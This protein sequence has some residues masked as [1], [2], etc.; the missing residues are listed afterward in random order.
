MNP[1]V[2]HTPIVYLRGVGTQRAELLKS[3]L[4]IHQFQDLL[5]LFPNRYIDRTRFYKISE[6]QNNSAEVQIVG[7]IIHL[8]TVSSGNNNR[9][10]ATFTDDINTMEL[11]G[12]RAIKWLRDTLKINEPYVIYGKINWFNGAFSMP[13]PENGFGS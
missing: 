8:K 12:L 6:L 3:E 13:H 1:E 5:N 10:V 2:L 9:L 11:V 4:G 7:K